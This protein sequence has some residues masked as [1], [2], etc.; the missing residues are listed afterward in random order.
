MKKYLFIATA[1]AALASCSSDEFVGENTTPTNSNT[2][3]AIQ[4]T[5]DAGKNTRATSN[6]GTTAQKLDG[7]FLV[8]GVKSGTTAG[9]NLQKVFINYR[10][11][12]VTPATTSNSRGWEYVGASG[13]SNLG[14]GKISLSSDQTIKYWDHSAA[15]YRFVAGSPISAFTFNIDETADNG[16]EDN[17]IVSAT[18]TG[19]AGHLNPNPSETK[20]PSNPV[21][22]ADPL[23]I[24]ESSYSTAY[25][26]APV[27]FNFT[28]QQASVRV[29]IYETIPGYVIKEIHFYTNGAATA[30]TGTNLI[31]TSATTDYFTGATDGTAT[32]TYDWTTT[33]ASYTF[34]NGTGMTSAQNWYGGAYA[35]GDA[36]TPAIPAIT[37]TSTGLWGTDND[38]DASGYFTVIP[39]PSAT[40]AAPLLIKCDY[41]LLSEK[42]SSGETITVTGAT[43]AVPDVFSKWKPNTTYTYLFKISDNTN[44]QTNPDKPTVGLYPITFDAVVT[45]E[46]DGT[47]QG[48]ITTVTTPSITTY[49][50]E[51]VT[52][53]GIKY[54]VD[55]PIYITVADN[56]TGEL[57]RLYDGGDAVGGVQVYSLGATAKTE[58]DMQVT[59]PTGTDMFNLPNAATTIQLTVGSET[60]DLVTLPVNKHG[61]FTPTT[62]GYYA[63]QY[64]TTAT[65]GSD[66][67]AY[68]Y[69]IVHVED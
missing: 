64:L 37:S 53:T 47:K 43:A 4:F 56:T 6:E 68:T 45:A 66:P 59:A 5:P 23:K 57:N 9:S 55:K 26:T 13:A 51:S 16:V 14:T 39:T 22:I 50:A 60:H 20:L 32:I 1:L 49:Q 54:V 40:T 31:L 19:L 27:T 67:A 12:D 34:A 62:A 24:A 61:Y 52:T 69:K 15:D 65:S 48:T 11:W 63:I 7:Q 58:A 17:S 41:V 18:V 33:P 2:Y 42:D 21:Y 46:A 44:G 38:M 28:R 35:T 25:G 8:Y 10:V 29:G 3:G 36:T 30:E